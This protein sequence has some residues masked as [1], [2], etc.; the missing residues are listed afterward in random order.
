MRVEDGRGFGV[1]LL[2]GSQD[3]DVDEEFLLSAGAI[4]V[5]HVGPIGCVMPFWEAPVDGA[6][7][8]FLVDEVTDLGWEGEEARG[9]WAGCLLC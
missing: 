5:E 4:V 8:E 6:E 9:C 7:E 3:C 2:V 1:D